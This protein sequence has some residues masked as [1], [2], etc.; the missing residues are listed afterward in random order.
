MTGKKGSSSVH[1][2]GPVAA[3]YGCV[4]ARITRTLIVKSLEGKMKGMFRLIQGKS[5]EITYHAASLPLAEN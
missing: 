4:L 5:L 3:T 2:V 1:N